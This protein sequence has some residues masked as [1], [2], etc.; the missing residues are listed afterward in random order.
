MAD[1]S[2]DDP[3]KTYPSGKDGTD[4]NVFENATRRTDNSYAGKKDDKSLIGEDVP[5]AEQD[6]EAGEWGETS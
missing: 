4:G 2:S 1:H 3:K 6:E 5:K